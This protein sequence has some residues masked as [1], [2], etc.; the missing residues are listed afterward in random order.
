M[1]HCTGL[2]CDFV[3]MSDADS[4]P[5]SLG[6]YGLAENSSGDVLA[7]AASFFDDFSNSSWGPVSAE[8]AEET[9]LETSN[10]D[11][12]DLDF[13][14]LPD[15]GTSVWVRRDTRSCDVLR[16]I[17]LQVRNFEDEEAYLRRIDRM[18]RDRGYWIG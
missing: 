11:I 2:T 8:G 17:D 6:S 7:S 12:W 18:M 10:G 9:A 1:L 5:S 15:V 4:L 13:V 3:D 16:E 14:Q